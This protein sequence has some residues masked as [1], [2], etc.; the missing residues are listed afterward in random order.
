MLSIA[1]RKKSRATFDFD[2]PLTPEADEFLA[3]ATAEFNQ[4]QKALKTN[5]RFGQHKQWGFDQQSGILKLEFADGAELH[6]DG[7]ILGSYSPSQHSWEWAWNNP[8]VE[9]AMARD[10]RQV[11]KLGDRFNIAYLQAGLVPLPDGQFVSYLCS[12]GLKATDSVGVYRG[13]CDPV[14]VI[15]LLKKPR[16]AKPARAKRK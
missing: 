5:W 10:S 14:D 6:F 4:K 1:K 15:I 3:Q 7:Q 13:Q 2:A 12:I 16:W 9:A 8:W 11:K